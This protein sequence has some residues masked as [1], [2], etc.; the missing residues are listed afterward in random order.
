MKYIKQFIER[1]PYTIKDYKINKKDIH[2]HTVFDE[3]ISIRKADKK[4][5]DVIVTLTEAEEQRYLS[6]VLNIF[7]LFELLYDFV[8]VFD[9]H[10]KIIEHLK[11]GRNEL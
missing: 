1:N 9:R 7:D 8:F 6:F 2:I 4:N 10:Y 11:E 3:I 5:Y